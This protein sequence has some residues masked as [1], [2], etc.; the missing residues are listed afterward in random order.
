MRCRALT[1]IELLVVVS[2]IAMLIAVLLPALGQARLSAQRAACLS[3]MRQLETAHWAYLVDNKGQMLGTTHGGAD[4][5]WI[6]SLR[7]Y[8]ENLLLRSPL[9]TSPHFIGGTPIGGVYRQASYAI[10]NNL[11][12]D[13]AAGVSRI[14]AVP[15]P[16]AVVHFTLAVFEGKNAVA[17]HVHPNAW[18]SPLTHLIP[19][20]AGNE[21]QINAHGGDDGTWEARSAYGFLDGHAEVRAFKD[22]YIDP[23]HNAVDP[24]VA[25]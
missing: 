11:S 10:N 5:S 13:N 2:I 12:P 17:D 21:M 4:A 3:N 18:F 23:D 7:R 24:G 9:D 22:I 25:R 8:D 1:L 6:E 20:K 15:R 19:G 14:D 16:A